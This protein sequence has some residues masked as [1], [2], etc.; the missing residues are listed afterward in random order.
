M[1][2]TKTV[3]AAIMLMAVSVS[4]KAQNNEPHAFVDLGLPSGTLW[5]ET[6]VGASGQ[7]GVGDVFSW[8]ETEPQTPYQMRSTY[9]YCITN[10]RNSCLT[11]YC[12]NSIFGCDSF[13]D[14]LILL[15]E[16]DDAAVANWGS[17]WRIPTREQWKELMDNTTRKWSE[18]YG[19][20]GCFLI[21]QNGNRIFLPAVGTYFDE[22]GFNEQVAGYYW[23]SSL[24]INGPDCAHI[25]YF[26]ADRAEMSSFPR[27]NGM[28]I[29]P[30]R[31]SRKNKK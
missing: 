7:E 1:N 2:K 15:Q 25:F 3:L 30:V 18:W 4:A 17:D 19:V 28:S 13:V 5:A 11:K 29:R 8:G 14:K 12:S 21:G 24:D 23:S 31:V 9:K 20:K 16:D 22:E 26:D 27:T 6:N 10:N